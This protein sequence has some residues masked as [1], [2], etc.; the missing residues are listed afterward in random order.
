MAAPPGSQHEGREPPRKL[1]RVI[2]AILVCQNPCQVGGNSTS[3]YITLQ[4][5]QHVS[6]PG[7]MLLNKSEFICTSKAS[8]CL[9]GKC[10]DHSSTDAWNCHCLKGSMQTTGGRGQARPKR[11]LMK[12][13]MRQQFAN[14]AKEPMQ[15]QRQGRPGHQPFSWTPLPR[16]RW[17]LCHLRYHPWLPSGPP[18]APPAS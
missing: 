14:A 9:I 15:E 13:L 11:G 4:R 17:L 8:S 3:H 6:G 5:Q 12:A 18:V 1:G 16:S 7:S 10:M 2:C